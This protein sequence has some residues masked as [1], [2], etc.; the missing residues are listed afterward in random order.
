M[1]IFCGAG[2]RG[3]VLSG[4]VHGRGGAIGWRA[5]GAR[6]GVS[7]RAP[8]IRGVVVARDG[9]RVEGGP[10]PSRGPRGGGVAS[11]GDFGGGREH[12]GGG[13]RRKGRLARGPSRGGARRYGLGSATRGSAGGRGS[14]V[15]RVWCEPSGGSG[16]RRRSGR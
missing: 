6:P 15:C 7:G 2:G 13:P 8:R 9:G 12:V 11:V 14:C 4:G 10:V 3:G 5:R 16:G 1:L